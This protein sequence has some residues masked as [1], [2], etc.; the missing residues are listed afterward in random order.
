MAISDTEEKAF[1]VSLGAKLKQQRERAKLSVA[2]LSERTGVSESTISR[3]EVGAE[4]ISVSSLLRLCSALGWRGP[5]D[6]LASKKSMEPCT[7]L[8]L[9]SPE[10]KNLLSYLFEEIEDALTD[11]CTVNSPYHRAPES[12]AADYMT[13]LRPFLANLLAGH[14]PQGTRETLSIEPLVYSRDSIASYVPKHTPVGIRDVHGWTVQVSGN[15]EFLCAEKLKFMPI[16]KVSDVFNTPSS[17]YNALS[18][19]LRAKRGLPIDALVIVP[20]QVI[21]EGDDDEPL[22]RETTEGELAEL[23]S[24]VPA[25]KTYILSPSTD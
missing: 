15:P 1:Y 3:I 4:G 10:T 21:S 23:Y 16:S 19:A 25:K 6:A 9:E 22:W 17:A 12:V 5:M 24:F 7:P 13:Y 18:T 11:F 2:A 20:V 8:T 14:L